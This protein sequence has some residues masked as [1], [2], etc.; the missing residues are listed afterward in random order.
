[1][2]QNKLF[3]ALLCVVSS[4]A[5]AAD[6]SLE[7]VV[8]TASRFEEK[9]TNQ[10]VNMTVITRED[11][12]QSSARTLPELL[13]TQA[14]ITM[15]DLFGN[16]AASASVDM[17]GFGAAAGQNTLI[18]LDGRRITD[19]DL[20]GVQ[21]AAIPF[22]AIQRIEIM[23]GSGAVLYGD[24]ATGGVINIITRAPAQT[25]GH[26]GFELRTGS[27]DANE[28]QARGAYFSGAAGIDLTASG[29]TSEGYRANNRNEQNNVQA[30]LRWFTEAGEW[31]LKLGLDRQDV[32]LPGA[33]A[34]Q[35]ALG[36]DQVATDPRGTSTPLDFARRDGDQVALEWQH[37]LAG[38]D[39]HLGVAH[40]RKNQKAFFDFG[41]FPIYRDSDLTVD[42]FTPRVRLPHAVG[43]DSTLVLGA[44]VHRWDYVLR[45]SNA[46]GNIGRPINRVKMNQNNTAVYLQNSAHVM[47][48]TW[49]LLG[50][51][52]EHISMN[53][54]DVYD[55][56]APGAF[57]GTAAPAGAFSDNQ[58]AYEVGLRQQINEAITLRGKFGRSFRL[59]NVD[60]I[61]ETDP[62]F[63]N[64]FQF[65]RAQTANGV[66]IGMEQQGAS[67][68]WS[69]T[70]FRNE[71]HNEIHLD[72]FT[73]GV[74]NTNLPPSRRQG[75]E[76]DG[77]WQ[78]LS[79]LNLNAA[80]TYTHARFLQGVLPGGPFTQVN[81]NIAGK[82]V[83]LVP[84]H[85]LTLAASW[86]LG[87][88]T[89]LNAST[90]Y[91]GP[92]FMDNDEANTLGVKIPSY[93]LADL[94]LVHQVGALK[95]DAAI[96]NLF[97][98]HYFNYAVSSQFTPG[99]YNAYPLPGRTFYLGLGYQL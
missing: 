94:K 25:D 78:A 64:Q 2:K 85:T 81:V 11:M 89:R 12:R 29:L 20:S 6:D 63:A 57:F 80:Y 48:D 33:R 32:R 13:S 79:R 97:D 7:E 69:V 17:R 15:R 52:R 86:S 10:P 62:S 56:G 58:S 22:A 39:T 51:R 37:S 66:E 24:G 41:G 36:I 96:N 47:A 4:L 65:L 67:G 87:E 71:V 68:R 42:S 34:V 23:R 59:A 3:A 8:V 61:Y 28:L 16:N 38:A 5:F 88:Q 77:K 82:H 93:T 21:W 95:F 76:L 14:G 83:P 50:W 99:R 98:R 49:L 53:G 9:S 18:L 60:E 75:V 27:Y 30:N 43:G 46:V 92:Q 91:V 74:G 70:G 40:R 72:A 54:R 73:T 26:G 55:A 44:D 1:M 19:P 31:A 84:T 90:R 45:T 35:P